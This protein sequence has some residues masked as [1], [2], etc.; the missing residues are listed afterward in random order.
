MLTLASMLLL[1]Q[2]RHGRHTMPH[3]LS[4]PQ[5][6]KR[7]QAAVRAASPVN[8]KLEIRESSG[9]I[10]TVSF[11]A[12]YPQRYFISIPTAG[13]EKMEMHADGKNLY[14]YSAAQNKYSKF[15]ITFQFMPNELVLIG[16]ERAFSDMDIYNEI[17][18]PVK[19]KFHGKP[20]YAIKLVTPESAGPSYDTFYIDTKTFLPLGFESSL[21]KPGKPHRDIDKG[22]YKNVVIHARLT[23]KDF[24]W[25]PPKG[26]KS[27]TTDLTDGH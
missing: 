23:K 19:G 11:K 6:V 4:G 7:M 3:Q 24:M 26:A 2:H 1:A 25:S 10:S 22:V 5:I 21:D 13:V 8:G 12:M 27:F 18:K 14:M 20:V 17:Q 9:R 15:P 16:Y